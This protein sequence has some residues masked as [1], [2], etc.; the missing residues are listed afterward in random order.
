MK[1]IGAIFVF[2]E[3]HHF[4][5]EGIYIRAGTVLRFMQNFSEQK[6]GYVLLETQ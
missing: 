2:K 4:V 5:L 1:Q 6:R 3:S